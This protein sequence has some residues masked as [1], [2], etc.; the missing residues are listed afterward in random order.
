[1]IDKTVLILRHQYNHDYEKTDIIRHN[2]YVC[3]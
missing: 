2:H 1:M 3:T